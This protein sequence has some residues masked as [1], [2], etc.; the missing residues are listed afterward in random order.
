MI[1]NALKNYYEILASDET[2]AIPLFGYSRAKVGFALNISTEGELIDVINL[3]VEGIKGKKLV[4]SNIDSA[5][6][7]NSVR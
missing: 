2:S 3:K 7:K 4:P 5:R 1:I 6:A